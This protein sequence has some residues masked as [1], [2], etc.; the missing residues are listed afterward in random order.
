MH[1]WVNGGGYN[2]NKCNDD[3][4]TTVIDDK[5]KKIYMIMIMTI[6]IFVIVTFLTI[7]IPLFMLLLNTMMGVLSRPFY[8]HLKDDVSIVCWTVCSGADQRK[9][10]SFTSLAFVRGIHRSS[11]WQRV[12]NADF[13]A[14]SAPSHYLNQ[15]WN[16]VNWTFRK[17][18]L[19]WNF[20]RNSSIFIQEIAFENL[21]CKMA[22]ILSR[23]QWVN[24]NP[25]IDK[26]LRLS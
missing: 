13:S 22:S 21:V 6:V 15:C 12:S 10:Q 9:H 19:Q 4:I 5:L 23:P 17:N 7:I 1:Y 3:R 14:C 18:R 26:Y 2:D 11:V 16:I 25:C 8:A 24:F 20:N